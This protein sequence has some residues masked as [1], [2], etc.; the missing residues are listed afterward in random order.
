MGKFICK[1]FGHYWTHWGYYN[2]PTDYSHTAEK[3]LSCGIIRD[4][5]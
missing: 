5:K 2:S 3:C 4:L 1:I